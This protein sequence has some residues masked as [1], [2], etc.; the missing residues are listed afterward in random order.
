MDGELD[1]EVEIPGDVMTALH[2]EE[3]HTSF[4]RN[5]DTVLLGNM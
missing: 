1:D 5:I 3:S 4:E 2:T